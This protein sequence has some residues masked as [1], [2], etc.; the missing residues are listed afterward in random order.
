[1]RRTHL[2]S[3]VAAALAGCFLVA[4]PVQAAAEEPSNPAAAVIKSHIMLTP[5]DMK[6]EDC[7][8]GPLPAGA[9]CAIVEG[10]RSTPNVLFTYRL[11]MPDN[12]KIAPHF[13]P[14]DEHLTVISGTF[15]MGMGDKFDMKAS[16]A[17]TAGSFMVM[18]KGHAHFAWTKGET[19]LQVHAIGPW[20]MT[21]VNP[22]DDPRSKR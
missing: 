15:N 18:P 1:M 16:T 6:W 10:N 7:P 14:A 17:M 13:H 12:Y 4:G 3:N 9:K 2:G 11:K 21:Y 19:I 20:G 5:G 22:K 8:P